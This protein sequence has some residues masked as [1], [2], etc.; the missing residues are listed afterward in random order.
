MM[1]THPG[2]VLCHKTSLLTFPN[3]PRGRSIIL[4]SKKRKPKSG[5]WGTKKR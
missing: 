4:R 5:R 3:N 2:E 1:P